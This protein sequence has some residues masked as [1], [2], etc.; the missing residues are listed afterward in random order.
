[1]FNFHLFNIENLY[2]QLY[3]DYDLHEQI[4]NTIDF[5]KGYVSLESVAAMDASNRWV[6]YKEDD[7][8]FI[9]SRLW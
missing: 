6:A 8:A 2:I 4:C 9:D 5:D 1:M 3:I 7:V